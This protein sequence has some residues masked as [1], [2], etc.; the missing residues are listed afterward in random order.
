MRINS[1]GIRVQD[2]IR[3]TLTSPDANISL[4]AD[5]SIKNP[6]SGSSFKFTNST[7]SLYYDGIVVGDIK[8]PAGLARARRTAKMNTSMDV[9]AEKLFA[10]PRFIRDVSSGSLIFQGWTRIVGRL[11]LMKGISTELGGIGT[12]PPF[13]AGFLVL[14]G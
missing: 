5:M 9:I 12:S 13:A 10:A 2:V 8:S 11:R 14:L 3:R 7:T 4:T 6:N 1:L